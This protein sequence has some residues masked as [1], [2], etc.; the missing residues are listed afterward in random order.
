MTDKPYLIVPPPGLLAPV[1]APE[2]T[3]EQ[4]IAVP[5]VDAESATHRVAPNVART[6]PPAPD[7]PHA[8]T[9]TIRP[10]IAW[11]LDLPHGLPS[12]ALTGSAVLGRNPSAVD[13]V[14]DAAL[15]P[16][17]DPAKSVSKTHVL[18]ELDGDAL[19]ITDLDSTNGTV[20]SSPTGV[21]LVLD[22]RVRTRVVDGSAISLGEFT[23]RAL[24]R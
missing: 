14:P 18:L 11:R 17:A 8:D 20:T 5:A 7:H 22:P 16:L 2:P 19:W 12:V 4:Y 3:R 1:A 24:R 23:M 21:Q 15:V 13:S 10:T 9:I 6:P